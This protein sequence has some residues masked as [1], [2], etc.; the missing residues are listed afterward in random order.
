MVLLGMVSSVVF[1]TVSIICWF[2]STVMLFHSL[3]YVNYIPI[4]TLTGAASTYLLNYWYK[5]LLQI[6]REN[7]TQAGGDMNE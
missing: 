5:Q 4:F 7:D 2:I 3:S 6:D 1:L